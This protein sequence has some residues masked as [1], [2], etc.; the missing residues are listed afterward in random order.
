VR[1]I[2]P[3]DYDNAGARQC[4]PVCCRGANAASTA[5]DDRYLLV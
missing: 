5:Q 2:V 3:T 1:E 4:K